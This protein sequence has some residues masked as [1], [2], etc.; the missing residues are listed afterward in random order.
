MLNF[1]WFYLTAY[2]LLD[3]VPG[4][5]LRLIAIGGLVVLALLLWMPPRKTAPAAVVQPVTGVLLARE[6]SI[7]LSTPWLAWG[8]GLFVLA[9]LCWLP[10]VVIQVRI[11]DIAAATGGEP[12]LPGEVSRLMWIWTSLGIPAFTALVAVFWLMVFKP[13]L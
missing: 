2:P 8:I 6:L 4:G 13:V 10:V 7:P 12:G 5:Q 1:D 11:R 9:G 3:V